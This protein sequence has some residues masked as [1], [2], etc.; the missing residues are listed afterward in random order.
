MKRQVQLVGGPANGKLVMV[1]RQAD[2]LVWTDTTVAVWTPGPVEVE[3]QV[4]A[5]M[6]YIYAPRRRGDYGWYFQGER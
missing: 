2:R 1:D 3:E 6:R 4:L 5:P